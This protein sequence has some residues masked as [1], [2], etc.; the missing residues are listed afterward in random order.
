M[1]KM[2]IE[3]F[4]FE[5]REELIC[6][7]EVGEVGADKWENGFRKWLASEGAKKNI[8]EQK[9]KKYY[10]IEDESEI[11]AIADE[12]L[13]ALENNSIDSYWKTFQ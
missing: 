11:F 10:S 2:E 7:D 9:G 3:D 4:V 13:E 6:Y 1:I 8:V 12:Y 5:V